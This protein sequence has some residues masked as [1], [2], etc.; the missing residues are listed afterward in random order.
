MLSH[1][2]L[3]DV[4]LLD[5]FNKTKTCRYLRNDE[6]DE[7]KWYC[8]KLQPNLKSRIDEKVNCNLGLETPCGDNCSG[9]PLL[10]HITQGYDVD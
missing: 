6:L 1:K 7:N 4:C 2:H 9:Y 5:S 8:Q 10:K 3:F